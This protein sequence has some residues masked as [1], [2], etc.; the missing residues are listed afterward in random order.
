MSLLTLSLRGCLLA[1][2]GE[3]NAGH[4][5][6]VKH[7]NPSEAGA[8]KRAA[9]SYGARRCGASAWRGKGRMGIW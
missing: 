3:T 8:S 7:F 5:P 6:V 1:D 2:G 9:T 4:A